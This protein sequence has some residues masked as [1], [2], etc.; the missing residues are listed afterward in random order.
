MVQRTVA[1]PDIRLDEILT[2]VISGKVSEN[3][4]LRERI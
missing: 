1:E 3:E 4:V 2:Q